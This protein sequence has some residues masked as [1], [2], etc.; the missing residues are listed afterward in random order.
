[1]NSN[2]K[3]LSGSGD[4]S[5]NAIQAQVPIPKISLGENME[6]VDQENPNDTN[7]SLVI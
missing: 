3:S 4:G 7:R 6:E 2:S 1:M 5:N